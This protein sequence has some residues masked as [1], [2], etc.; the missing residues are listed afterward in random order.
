M[1]CWAN[2]A[3]YRSFSDRDETPVE[4]LSVIPIYLCPS[5]PDSPRPKWNFKLRWIHGTG[6]EA[7]AVGGKLGTVRV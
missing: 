3:E 6:P 4:N 7:F 5:M 1:I 2:E